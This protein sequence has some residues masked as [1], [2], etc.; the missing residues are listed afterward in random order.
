[1]EFLLIAA[2]PLMFLLLATVMMVVSETSGFFT[3]TRMSA[4]QRATNRV[5]LGYVQRQ[6]MARRQLAV[7]SGQLVGL[8]ASLAGSNRELEQLN[9]LKSRFLSVAAHD[10]RTP[11]ASIR[12]FAESLSGQK[13]L[14][15]KDRRYVGNIMTAADQMGRLTADLTDLAIIEAGKLKME[16]APFDYAALIE[17]LWGQ[18]S[19]VAERKG[20]RLIASEL[21]RGLVLSGDRFRIGQVVSNLVGN[22]IKF[23]PAGGVVDL[24]VREA[25]SGVMTVVAD[26]GP[27]I[28]P[29]EQKRIFEKFYQARYGASAAAARQ[30]WGLG[31]SIASEIVQAHHGE[32]GVE[33]PGLGRGSKFW[34]FIPR[35]PAARR[36]GAGLLRALAAAALLLAFVLRT[37]AQAQ[38]LPLEDKSRYDKYLEQKVESVLV[39]ML[40]PGRAKVVVDAT[41]DFTR[42]EKFTVAGGEGKGKDKA[43]QE[44][45]YAWQ[46][47]VAQT[48]GPNEFLP[49]VPVHEGGPGGA[50]TSYERQSGFTPEFL[51]KLSVTLI[52][53]QS[54]PE[55]QVGDIQDIVTNLLQ[56][57]EAR[58]DALT[59]VRTT[60]PPPWKTMW[61][62]QDSVSMVFRY[63]IL[64]LLCLATLTVVAFCFYRLAGAMDAMAR[65]QAN[66][67]FD[68][69]QEAA[70]LGEP[71]AEPPAIE[72]E[73]KEEPQALP[74]PEGEQI[75]IAVREDQMPVLVTMM[76]GEEP[77]NI[78][79]VMAHLDSERRRDFMRQMPRELEAKVLGSLAQV[80]FVE[81]SLVQSIKEEIERRLAGAVGGLHSVYQIV[82]Q[83]DPSAKR[84]LLEI[85]RR[86]DPDLAKAVRSRILLMEDLLRLSADGWSLL[87][88]RVRLEDW[89]S[90]LRDASSELKDALRSQMLPRT[91]AI[92][93]Q[94]AE[95]GEATP[96]KL[97]AAQ[98]A[99]LDEVSRM[100][101]ANLIED[102]R[103]TEDAP[104]R[105]EA[106]AVGA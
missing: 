9:S 50:P 83:A 42:I 101:S 40:G 3:F 89:A 2:M 21:P 38:T 100:I 23:T 93:E 74:G 60:F 49:G 94:V 81:E 7:R 65:S 76:L 52:V 47:I 106:P 95:S 46:N 26:T 31:L 55:K 58:G 102:P 53:D 91:W 103:P 22:A 98:S 75:V 45:L 27:G 72:A 79:L 12:G 57:D 16:P 44:A 96:E 105:L 97:A 66:Y 92:L 14:T 78:A 73:Q 82:D 17:E 71:A 20:V 41:V 4:R 104:Q 59:V 5:L 43:G 85:L 90:A 34:F 18:L 24:R 11:L 36:P 6:R 29:S 64:G 39:D 61:Y 1:M 80:R 30:G 56:V 10:M 87:T 32:I 84:E 88:G 51:K 99:I 15:P 63:S 8:S 28:H 19:L 13:M 67:G 37:G 70:G 35:E 77:E 69:G 86:T 33:S 62:S 54:V 48:S 25:A 68:L